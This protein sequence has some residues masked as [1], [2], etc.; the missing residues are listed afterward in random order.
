MKTL[1]LRIC[2]ETYKIYF[3]IGKYVTNNTLAIEARFIDKNGFEDIYGNVSKNLLISDVIADDEFCPDTDNCS[4]LIHEMVEQKLIE[5]TGE[6][7][8]CDLLRYP[9]MKLTNKFKEYIKDD[10]SDNRF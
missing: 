6:T 2:G 9:K 4:R 5:D 8:K 1:N 7:L 10:H 3:V